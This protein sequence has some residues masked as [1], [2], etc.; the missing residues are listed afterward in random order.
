MV[1]FK[2]ILVGNVR[3]IYELWT[4]EKLTSRDS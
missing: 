4:M 3:D 1:A 2:K